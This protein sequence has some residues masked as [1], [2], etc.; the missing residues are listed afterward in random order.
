M[1]AAC[2]TYLL[3]FWPI[4]PPA[5]AVHTS[6]ANVLKSV[7]NLIVASDLSPAALATS[8]THNVPPPLAQHQV[9]NGAVAAV[10]E[11]LRR[12]P[13]GVEARLAGRCA[14]VDNVGH[15]PGKAALFLVSLPSLHPRQCPR[16]TGVFAVVLLASLPIAAET[17]RHCRRPCHHQTQPSI[18]VATHHRHSRITSPYRHR[19]AVVH[20]RCRTLSRS[21]RHRTSPP[22]PPPP[23]SPAAAAAG[24]RC[25]RA[26]TSTTITVT[27]VVQLTVVHCQRKTQHQHHHQRTNDSTNVRTFTSSDNLD[28]FNVYL[29][30]V[31]AK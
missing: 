15:R 13:P 4:H 10:G 21:H 17:C 9:R 3:P 5:S 2:V 27:S 12:L 7:L 25:R 26:T 11:V 28:L 23:Q 24:H 29:Q 14:A 6:T 18:A 30:Y 1:L 31:V 8:H 19:L 22:P 16:R 20:C